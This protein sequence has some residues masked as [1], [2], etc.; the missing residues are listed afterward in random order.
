MNSHAVVSQTFPTSQTRRY[1]IHRSAS[2]AT[3]PVS[4]SSL[5]I[6]DATAGQVIWPSWSRPI[7]KMPPQDGPAGNRPMIAIFPDR[8]IPWAG[9][10]PFMYE[11]KA[12]PCGSG[13]ATS[14][15]QA[16]RGSCTKSVDY[17]PEGSISEIVQPGCNFQDR[18]LPA[19][20][21][22]RVP[23]GTPK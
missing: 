20:P 22:T 12:R 17:A 10:R 18:R 11:D 13:R 1:R 14:F 9:A 2:C 4:R 3:L 5:G 21:P 7:L 6:A 19:P 8:L 15:H 16:A 23:P